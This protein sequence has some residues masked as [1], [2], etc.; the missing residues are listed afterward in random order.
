MSK[1]T[2][3]ELERRWRDYSNE[4][5]TEA[6]ER[7]YHIYV[8]GTITKFDCNDECSLVSFTQGDSVILTKKGPGSIADVPGDIGIT[9]RDG[10]TKGV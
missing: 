10:R 3:E 1:T 5:L 4:N 9:A 6:D 2:K 7:K 8:A